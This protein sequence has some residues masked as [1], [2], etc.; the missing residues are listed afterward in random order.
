MNYNQCPICNK[1]MEESGTYETLLILE[2][3][4]DQYK[5]TYRK[6]TPWELR[7]LKL[8]KLFKQL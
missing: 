1:E 8:R 6:H 3:K 2:C 4:K 5:L 7:W